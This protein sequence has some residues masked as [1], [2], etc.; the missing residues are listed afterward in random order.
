MNK[1]KKFPLN[2]NHRKVFVKRVFITLHH[3]N[4][5]NLSQVCLNSK[6]GKSP[7]FYVSDFEA[8]MYQSGTMGRSIIGFRAKYI[9][10]VMLMEAFYFSQM[11]RWTAP[12]TSWPD[13]IYHYHIKYSSDALSHHLSLLNIFTGNCLLTITWPSLR[14]SKNLSRYHSTICWTQW[15]VFPNS[16]MK[17]FSYYIYIYIYFPVDVFQPTWWSVTF[18]I[19]WCFCLSM[20]RTVDVLALDVSVCLPFDQLPFEVNQLH[21]IFLFKLCCVLVWNQLNLLSIL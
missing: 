15:R 7:M 18:S 9:Y 12:V 17:L 6:S 4:I 19:C 21:D 3:S 1:R 14:C 5:S 13:L 20:F 8:V 16:N 10:K 2:L 11:S